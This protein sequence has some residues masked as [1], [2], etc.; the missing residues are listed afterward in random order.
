MSAWTL[1]VLTAALLL[2]PALLRPGRPAS[3]RAAYWVGDIEVGLVPLWWL[4][5]T[6]CR[7]WHRLPF[8]GWAPL[9]DAGPAILIANHTCC[10]DHLLLQARCQRLLGFIIAREMYELPLVHRF[11][12]R[13]GCIPV[14][15]DGRDIRATRAALRALE[16]GRVLPVFPEGRI[17]PE[18][19]RA[20]G[21][22]RSGAAFLAVR[23]GA[24]V[25]PAFISGTP[26]TIDIGPSLWRPSRSRVLFGPP[27]DLSDFHPDQAADK[28]VLAQVCRRFDAAFRELQARSL[29]SEVQPTPR[30]ATAGVGSVE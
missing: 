7:V 22:M 11:C 1:I 26:A 10:I 13:T 4:G 14:D 6:Y 25:V 23:S 18:S 5:R 8:E 16:E 27:I 24:P 17:T 29:A 9:P 2:V 28:E 21:P 12:V 15:R 30:Q 19:G 20:L 3:R